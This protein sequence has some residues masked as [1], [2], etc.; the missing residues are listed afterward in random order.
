M[1]ARRACTL[2]LVGVGVPSQ[3]C[4]STSYCFRLVSSSHHGDAGGIA[5][6]LAKRLAIQDLGAEIDNP[7]TAGAFVETA[8]VMKNLDL[9]IT[10]DTAM[11]HVAGALGVPLWV[12]LQ[13]SPNWRWLVGRNDSP[14]YPSMRLFRQ[15]K[16]NVWDDVFLAMAQALPA[17]C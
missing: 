14:W 9:I 7:S 10:T 4:T 6:P 1:S 3:E 11:A 13:R 2:L 15:T 12:A 8:A 5:A 16:F 17:S